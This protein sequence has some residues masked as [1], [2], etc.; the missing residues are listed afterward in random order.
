M[1]MVNMTVID[2]FITFHII[3]FYIT[4]GVWYWGVQ[5]RH[6]N[7][8]LLNQQNELYRYFDRRQEVGV[9]YCPIV[10]ASFPH[11]SQWRRVQP[12]ASQ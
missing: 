2:I 8:F 9:F 4:H 11:V 10:C 5:K 3:F 6:H 12:T 1:K 7:L